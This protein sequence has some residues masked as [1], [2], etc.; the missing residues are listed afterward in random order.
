MKSLAGPILSE[1]FERQSSGIVKQQ[2]RITAKLEI[3]KP[4][5]LRSIAKAGQD[6][7]LKR[8]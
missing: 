4:L 7:A 6:Q 8:I 5:R 3:Q 1:A 2:I